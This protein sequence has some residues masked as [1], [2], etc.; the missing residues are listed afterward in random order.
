M[1]VGA[2]VAKRAATAGPEMGQALAG[3]AEHAAEAASQ[4][5]TTTQGG[6]PPA[7]SP[8]APT[9]VSDPPSPPPP[10]PRTPSDPS[11]KEF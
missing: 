7:H 2:E 6:A 8:A 10:V 4:P 1:I 9:Y 3:Q 11:A 5:G